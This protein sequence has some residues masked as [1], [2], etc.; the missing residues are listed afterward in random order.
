MPIFP[1]KGGSS[2]ATGE[3]TTRIEVL[4]SQQRYFECT[5]SNN[6]QHTL[7]HV[8]DNDIENAT[9][10]LPSHDK[11]GNRNPP[12]DLSLTQDYDTTIFPN[13]LTFLGDSTKYIINSTNRGDQVL[14]V[15][16]GDVFYFDLSNEPIQKRAY[17]FKNLNLQTG[18]RKCTPSK[19]VT[20][21]FEDCDVSSVGSLYYFSLPRG[22]IRCYL[23]QSKGIS[24]SPVYYEQC[25]AYS[26]AYFPDESRIV[27]GSTFLDSTSL[28]F[29]DGT[30]LVKKGFVSTFSDDSEIETFV[31]SQGETYSLPR[32]PNNY[33]L[34]KILENHDIDGG[35]ETPQ[36]ESTT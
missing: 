5:S 30:Y 25:S 13:N 9:I 36:E 29:F 33:I 24:T 12:Y 35:D 32:L 34:S 14:S 23:S 17:H 2:E 22:L 20:L 21:T 26:S 8:I 11:E 6:F 10:Y 7:Q 27:Y 28:Y 19:A 1:L 4:E 16:R 18:S 3:N 31:D 15:L